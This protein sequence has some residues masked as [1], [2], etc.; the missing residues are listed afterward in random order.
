MQWVDPITD[1]GMI[2][3]R[4]QKSLAAVFHH[5]ASRHE[6]HYH[7]NLDPHSG[8]CSL[9][10]FILGGQDGLVN[11]LGVVLGVAT[12][13]R[14]PR[15]ILV[16]GLATAF[17]ESISMGAVAYT[18]T[19]A[20]ADIYES[21]RSRE[22]RHIENAPNIERQEVREIFQKKGFHGTLLDRIVDTITAD[23]ETWVNVMMAEEHQLTPVN[24]ASAFRSAF[25]VGLSAIVGSLVPLLP[26]IFFPAGAGIWISVIVT[27]LVLFMVGAYKAR[28]TIGRPGKSGLEM[29]LIGI[30]S[31]L[32]GFVVGLVFKAPLP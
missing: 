26:F 23:H 1:Q 8:I 3:R 22:Y 29:A 6:H 17:A 25:V 19:M 2:Q 15:L 24:R 14:D 21:E 18:T 11:V 13:T 5:E 30:L 10:D 4:S 27:A 20:E 7:A 31:A 9:S 12:A 32:I 16:A 28:V